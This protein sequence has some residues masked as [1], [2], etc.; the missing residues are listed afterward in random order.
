MEWVIRSRNDGDL[1]GYPELILGP[2]KPPSEFYRRV[3]EDLGDFR[4]AYISGRVKYGDCR[5]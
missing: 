4:R 2:F 1:S 5:V 3:G